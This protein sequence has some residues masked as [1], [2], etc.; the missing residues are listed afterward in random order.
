[1]S[2]HIPIPELTN[3]LLGDL[4]DPAVGPIDICVKYTLTILQVQAIVRTEEFRTLRDAVVE[5]AEARFSLQL[6]RARQTALD[7]LTR[8]TSYNAST[9]QHAETIRKAVGMILRWKPAPAPARDEPA[10]QNQAETSPR[11]QPVRTTDPDTARS[12]PVPSPRSNPRQHPAHD[13]APD[14]PPRPAGITVSV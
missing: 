12:A 6:P 4:L 11:T 2:T 3:E 10:E 8:I 13:T 9:P 14:G 5:I 7:Q 1:M